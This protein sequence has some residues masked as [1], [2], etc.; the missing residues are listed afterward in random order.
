M[1]QSIR[2]ISQCLNKMPPGEVKVDDAKVSPPKRAEMKVSAGTHG[3][4]G[5]GPWFWIQS[6]FVVFRCQRILGVRVKCRSPLFLYL[7]CSFLVSMRVETP[8][9]LGNSLWDTW[10]LAH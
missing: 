9:V 1:R 5:R 10:R 3:G 4:L 2:I 7:L 8:P 6:C